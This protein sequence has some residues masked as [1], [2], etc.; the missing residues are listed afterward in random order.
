MPA[1]TWVRLTRHECCERLKASSLIGDDAD[2]A[3][4]HG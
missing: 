1:L 3:E 4:R 2:Y